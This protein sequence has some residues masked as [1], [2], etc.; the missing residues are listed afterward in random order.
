MMLLKGQYNLFDLFPCGID[1]FLWSNPP[2]QLSLNP[3]SGKGRSGGGNAFQHIPLT[4]PSWRGFEAHCA[5][6]CHFRLVPLRDRPLPVVKS[7]APTLPQSGFRKGE[8]WRGKPQGAELLGV[9]PSRRPRPK[10]SQ[11]PP[12]TSTVDA[13]VKRY[14]SIFSVIMS[15]N[16]LPGKSEVTQTLPSTARPSPC[17]VMV[18]RPQME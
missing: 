6:K 18:R 8:V 11:R 1:H 12:P 9:S 16:S 7:T 2:R 5:E 15:R 4:P 3:G 13:A 10:H 17:R 14:R